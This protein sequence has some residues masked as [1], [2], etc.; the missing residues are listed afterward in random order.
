MMDKADIL[1]N[2]WFTV[3][4]DGEELPPEIKSK[5][6]EV[7]VD[8]VEEG[9]DMGKVLMYDNDLTMLNN[10]KL[11]KDTPIVIGIGHLY[12]TKISNKFSGKISLVKPDFGED[13][14]IVLEITALESEVVDMDKKKESK[15]WENMTKS[16]V[17]K[18][19]FSKYGIKCE[20]TDTKI[21][22]EQISQADESD[23]EFVNRLAKEE[24]FI[25]Y[26]IK[27]KSYY[28]GKKKNSESPEREFSYR[29]GECNLYS[30]SPNFVTKL[31]KEKSE[32]V[33]KSDIDTNTGEVASSTKNQDKTNTTGK[34]ILVDKE[35]GNEV[36]IKERR[37]R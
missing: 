1:E 14:V 23:I 13:G 6:F 24:G 11:I 16:S 17:I 15:T 10:P 2:P 7:V 19:V 31:N 21:K 37:E 8:E 26:K 33:S 35:S 3:F 18:E 25:C 27:D 5:I 32:E 22:I 4:I 34:G 30:F 12:G 9:A 29:I 28:W 36:E 20:V